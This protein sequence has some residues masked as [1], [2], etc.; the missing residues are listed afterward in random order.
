VCVFG[1]RKG[2][3]GSGRDGC[4]EARKGGGAAEG[5]LPG[6]CRKQW[7]AWPLGAGC[8]GACRGFAGRPAAADCWRLPR[9]AGQAWRRLPAGGS[10]PRT[11]AEAEAELAPVPCLLDLLVVLAPRLGLRVLRQVGSRWAAGGRQVGGR[12]RA[13]VRVPVRQ[14]LCACA[15]RAEATAAAGGA[16]RVGGGARSSPGTGAAGGCCGWQLPARRRHAPAPPARPSCRRRCRRC[17][18]PATG[19]PPAGRC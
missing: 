1:G 19:A 6:L 13:A 14:R 16:G 4:R 12:R 10:P 9:P 17:R 8:E 5:L 3:A 7:L 18:C 2:G 11:C 15:R